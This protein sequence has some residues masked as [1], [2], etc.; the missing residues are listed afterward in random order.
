MSD[1]DLIESP[2]ADK[3]RSCLKLVFAASHTMIFERLPCKMYLFNA[4]AVVHSCCI[5][6]KEC[7]KVYS[8]LLSRHSLA[9]AIQHCG[10]SWSC[11]TPLRRRF[12]S[13]IS[14]R[15]M[16]GISRGWPT[17]PPPGYRIPNRRPKYACCR[18]RN[19]A[20]ALFCGVNALGRFLQV[21]PPSYHRHHN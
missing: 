15:L 9:A 14:V 21:E 13:Q 18:N 8:R 7:L 3:A 11:L 12:I 5:F 4:K 19:E 1:L 20:V 2:S 16:H 6:A 10:M 17:A